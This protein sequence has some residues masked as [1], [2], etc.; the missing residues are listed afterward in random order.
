MTGEGSVVTLTLLVKIRGFS[1]VI[2]KAPRLRCRRVGCPLLSIDGRL[3]AP[4]LRDRDAD[5]SA[6]LSSSIAASRVA[7]STPRR[8]SL[9][10]ASSG[11][12]V[13]A[14]PKMDKKARNGESDFGSILNWRDLGST[15]GTRV[16]PGRV[17]RTATPGRSS[18]EDAATILGLGVAR[19]LDLRSVDEFEPSP[20]VLQSRFQLRSFTRPADAAD[21]STGAASTSAAIA[22]FRASILDDVDAGRAV[23]YHSPLLDYDR[24]YRSIYDRMEGLE[25]VKA[26]VYTVQAKLYDD[27]NQR[28]LFVGKVN[29]GGLTLLNE[30]MVDGSGPEIAAAL[31]V[32]SASTPDGATAFYCKAGKDRT[33]LVAALALHCCG[34]SDDA[35]VAD[36]ARSQGSGKAALGGGK[37]EGDGTAIDY[38]R[39]HG[40]PEAVMRDTLSYIRRGYGSVEGYLDRV[41]FDADARRTLARALCE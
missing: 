3:S 7:R 22:A 34:A 1:R 25:R 35:I 11:S 32:L 29:A 15:P 26:A 6:V 9:P 39:F 37:V 19:L 13:D 17:F 27:T 20:G 36:Y 14:H 16:A 24:Y 12:D 38:S 30:V 2:I 4:A 5:M 33:G 18:E 41:G 8:R 40:A 21:P 28:R 31:C 10:R 23:R